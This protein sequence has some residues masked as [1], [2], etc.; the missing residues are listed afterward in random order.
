M[1]KTPVL[2]TERLILRPLRLEDAPAIQRRF[3]RWEIVRYLNA[4][5]PWPYPP[6]DA[7]THVAQCVAEMA[8]GEKHYWTI[9]LKGEPDEPIGRIDLWPDDGVSRDMRGFWLD[10]EYQGQGLMTEA[11]ERV[12]EYAFV[13]L[14]WPHLWLSN[15]EANSASGRI[16]EKQGAQF[17]ACEPAR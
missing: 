7:A 8:E 17:V 11:A 15:A 12:T 14:R 1:P 6:D 4:Q 13:E 5:V 3:P 9:T 10:P 16:K 2:E